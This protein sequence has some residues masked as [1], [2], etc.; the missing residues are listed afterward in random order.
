MEPIEVHI[1]QLAPMRVASAHGFGASPETLAWDKLTT[2]AKERGLW[3][4]AAPRRFF[5]FNNPDPSP[6]SPNY[7][8]ETWMTVGPDV[9]SD[10]EITVKNFSGG[11]YA[12]TRCEAKIPGDDIPNTWKQLAAWVETSPHQHARHQWLEEHFF[13]GETNFEAF[14]L[15]LFIPIR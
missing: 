9:D 2:W 15:D 8:Y 10:G 1:V 5:G 7:G 3:Q 13:Q 11:L 4:D 12:V 6:G 14:T